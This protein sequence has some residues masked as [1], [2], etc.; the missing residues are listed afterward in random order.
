MERIARTE[1]EATRAVIAGLQDAIV[2]KLN[3]AETRVIWTMGKCTL[4]SRREQT[5]W[6]IAQISRVNELT[7]VLLNV[8]DPHFRR[9]NQILLSKDRHR[10]ALEVCL[11]VVQDFRPPPTHLIGPLRELLNSPGFG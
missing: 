3:A 8:I 9:G 10:G 6:E 1:V 2:S 7:E 5:A 11:T 4:W